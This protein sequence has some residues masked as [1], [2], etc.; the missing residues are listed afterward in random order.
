MPRIYPDGSRVT[1][2]RIDKQHALEVVADT[3]DR[4]LWRQTVFLTAPGRSRRFTL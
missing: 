4:P 3:V 1:E 2:L